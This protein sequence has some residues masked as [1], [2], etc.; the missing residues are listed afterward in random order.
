MRLSSS[1]IEPSNKPLMAQNQKDLNSKNRRTKIKGNNDRS[2]I[3]ATKLRTKKA[4]ATHTPKPNILQR[5][6]E[7]DTSSAETK[8]YICAISSAM[9]TISGPAVLKD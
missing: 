5:D 3:N 2:G 1:G 7:Y 4:N 9:K 6:N 8:K